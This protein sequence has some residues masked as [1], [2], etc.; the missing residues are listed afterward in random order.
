[1]RVHVYGPG[2]SGARSQEVEPETRLGDLL[3]LADGERAYPM[4][5]DTE[6]D[7]NLSVAV[8]LGA[9]PGHVVISA[10]RK[11]IVTVTYGGVDKQVDVNPSARLRRV[12]KLA[13]DKA[14]E[15]SA[16]DAADLVLRLPGSDQDL[17][18]A[19]PVSSIVPQGSCSVVVDLV[20]ATR[21]QG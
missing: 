8:A 13:I 1:M 14:F 17:D 3:V 10:C 18:L 2:A 11:I 12:R 21:P 20:H 15:I 16:N 7:P 4:E 9:G 6:L 5:E 19:S